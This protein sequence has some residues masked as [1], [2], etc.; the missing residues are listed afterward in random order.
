MDRQGQGF[1][2][3]LTLF[4]IVMMVHFLL[5][6]ALT[7]ASVVA[8]GALRTFISTKTKSTPV[9]LLFVAA[10]IG[11]GLMTLTSQAELLT[12]IGTSVATIALFKLEGIAMR[13]CILLNSLCWLINNFYLGSIGGT[14][15]EFTFVIINLYSIYKLYSASPKK[16]TAI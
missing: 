6:G 11:V 10:I 16:S 13:A 9:M 12:I 5:L 4:S 15:V 7:S 14:A 1:R 2:N 8:L 3:K